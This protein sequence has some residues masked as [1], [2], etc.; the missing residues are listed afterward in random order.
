MFQGSFS[1]S[2]MASLLTAGLLLGN[3]AAFAQ[4]KAAAMPDAQI[5]A[6]VLKALAGAPELADQ[7][8][9]STTVY[10]TV[11]LNG[12]VRDEPSRDLAEHLVAN[13]AGVQKVVDQLMIGTPAAVNSD[14]GQVG[15]NPNLQS[16]GTIAP[17]DG[18]NPPPQNY[19]SSSAPQY[20]APPQ[21]GQYPQPPYGAPPQQGQYPAPDGSAP[22]AGQ[23]PPQQAGPYP[24]YGRPPY[25]PYPPQY[26]QQ[27]YVAQK[28]G[29]AVV[30]PSGSILRVRINQGMTSKN[31]APGTAFD[32]VVLGDVVAGG[33]IAIPRG[34]SIA[35]TV[36]D[37]HTAGQLGGKGELK[38]QLTNVSF[39]GKTYPVVTDF[40]WHQGVDKTGNT[41]G[42]TVGLASVGALIGAVAGGGVGAAVGAGVGGVAGLGVSSASGRGEAAL[43]PEAIVTFHLTKPADVTTVSQ[44]ELNRLG[45]G[46]PPP[47]QQPQM[48]RRYPPPPP[49]GYYSYPYYGP[50]Y[51]YPRY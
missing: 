5:E 25:Q 47:Q 50:G 15:T 44:A 2:S 19:P 4:T 17:P 21:Q 49:P 18:Q 23:Y 24:P 11:T 20:G 8:I 26:P 51:Y 32:G 35:G 30:V 7:S 14:S 36:V 46:V 13:T 42:T 29:D 34:A 37:S 22:Q 33:S 1:R 16:D 38:L 31:T 10:G 27:P 39:G 43:P 3:G 41:V 45:A 48:Q 40:W 9:T 12:T 28:G 6:N